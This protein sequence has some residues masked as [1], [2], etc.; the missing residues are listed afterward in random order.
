MIPSP[1]R[2]ATCACGRVELEAIGKPI[3]SA[4]CYCD[5][6]LKGAPPDRS[7]AERGRGGRSRWGHSLHPL[8]QGPDRLHTR[9]GPAEKLQA[10]ANVGHEQ[11]CRHVLQFG[12]VREFDRGPFWITAYRARFHGDVPPLQLR[13]CTKFKPTGAVL[14]RDVP[15]APGYPPLMVMKLLASR[16]A[17][18]LGDR[19][20]TSDSSP[21]FTVGLSFSPIALCGCIRP[22]SAT[23]E[24][25]N[26][27]ARIIGG[28]RPSQ[29]TILQY[30]GGQSHRRPRRAMAG[31]NIE[32][33][34]C[35][36]CKRKTK[37]F[38]RAE[39]EKKILTTMFYINS[40]CLL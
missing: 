37:H 23:I 39:F 33:F 26:H 9:R 40:A 19:P 21:H 22:I 30:A 17:M 20:S 14:P 29:S 34:F 31:E 8:S 10:Q 15:S 2:T 35:N 3:V 13:I 32:R 11:S 4:V 12:D 27:P 24:G 5:D 25:K 16:V 36:K 18:L 38:I 7:F 6:C 28:T 1:T